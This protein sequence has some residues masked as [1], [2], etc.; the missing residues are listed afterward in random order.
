MAARNSIIRSARFCVSHALPLWTLANPSIGNAIFV[1]CMQ[2]MGVAS[3]SDYLRRFAF[4]VFPCALL[5]ASFG[6]SSGG[7]LGLIAGIFVG[8][9]APVALLWLAITVIHVA[10]YLAIFCAG[11]VVLFYLARWLFWSGF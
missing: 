8:L 6:A 4:L 2:V 3:V 9:A 5:S 10:T 11:W 1:M 7:V